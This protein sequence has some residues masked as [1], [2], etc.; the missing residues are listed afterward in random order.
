MNRGHRQPSGD[1]K[2]P[3][4][5]RPPAPL[6]KGD[7]IVIFAC[8]LLAAASWWFAGH[9]VT[10][11][12]RRVQIS[13]DGRIVQEVLLASTTTMQRLSVEG[14]LGTSIIEIADGH[15]RVAQSPC[16]QQVCRR[17]GWLSA[18]GDLAACVPNRVVVRVIGRRGDGIDAVTR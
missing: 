5:L 16:H 18:P 8:V 14:R 17:A 15:A 1:L 13:V 7:S 10:E 3:V 4:P 2:P 11:G 9:A 6:T 12:P